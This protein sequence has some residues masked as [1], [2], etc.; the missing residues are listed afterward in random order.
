MQSQNLTNLNFSVCW[1]EFQLP[2]FIPF[3]ESLLLI[4]VAVVAPSN[5]DA[6]DG[7]LVKCSRERMDDT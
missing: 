7:G 3:S 6:R 5:N 1:E 4:L 2:P